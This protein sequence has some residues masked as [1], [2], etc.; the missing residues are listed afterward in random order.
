MIINKE[1]DQNNETK[2]NLRNGSNLGAIKRFPSNIHHSSSSYRIE[3]WTIILNK[4]IRRCY[5]FICPWP[6]TWNLNTFEWYKFWLLFSRL[7]Y[8]IHESKCMKEK[9][10]SKRKKKKKGWNVQNFVLFWLIFSIFFL[11]IWLSKSIRCCCCRRFIAAVETRE[12]D[13]DWNEWDNLKI[14]W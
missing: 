1:K 6:E 8:E 7:I 3:I 5:A 11:R 4:Q 2:V 14:I 12:P 13:G 9:N 10:I